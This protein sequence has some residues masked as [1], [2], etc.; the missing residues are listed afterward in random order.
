MEKGVSIQTIQRMPL[1]LNYLRELPS[2]ASSTISAKTIAEAL[3]L[4]EIQVRKDLAAVS[5]GGKPK[6]GYETQGLINEIERFLGYNE[7]HDAVLAGAGKLGRALLSYSGFQA[8]GMNIVAA[9][10]TDEASIGK[11]EGD[12]PVFA[13]EKLPEL[14]GRMN[15]R[16]GIITAPAQAAQRVCDLM[17]A[18]GILAI[19]NFAPA[20][21]RAP[22]NILIRSEN[23]AASLAVLGKHL[24]KTLGN[25]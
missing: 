10:D 25:D 3:S 24:Q 15:I 1:Y 4:G 6:I 2:G 23:M 5:S 16:V 7:I 11:S 9:F 14:V 8:Y 12:K 13:L 20:H 21:L 19:W 18:S 22:E 17:V